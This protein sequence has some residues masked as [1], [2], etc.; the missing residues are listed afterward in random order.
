MEQLV[1]ILERGWISLCTCVSIKPVEL[2]WMKHIEPCNANLYPEF[3][4]LL[5]WRGWKGE[6]KELSFF[7][8]VLLQVYTC[9]S[10]CL[11]YIHPLPCLKLCTLGRILKGKPVLTKYISVVLWFL[12]CLSFCCR[13]SECKEL[14]FW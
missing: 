2:S 3:T 7:G 14:S 11:W 5:I 1:L 13:G 8:C 10:S 4:V 6:L 9:G 12:S